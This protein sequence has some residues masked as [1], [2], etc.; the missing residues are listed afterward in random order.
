MENYFCLINKKITRG[1]EEGQLREECRCEKRDS[2]L[3]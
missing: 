2:T 3:E 1:K